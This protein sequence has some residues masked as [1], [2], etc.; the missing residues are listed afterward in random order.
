MRLSRVL[1]ALNGL[2]P[3]SHGQPFASLDAL[4]TSILDSI[5]SDMCPTTKRVLG[6]LL[7]AQG[8]GWRHT[9][10]KLGAISIVL[11]LDL[12]TIYASVNGCYSL[13]SMSDPEDA[14]WK[15]VTFYHASFGDYLLDLTQS[16]KFY[17]SIRD[18]EN[19]LLQSSFNI[20]QDFQTK[21]PSVPGKS[22]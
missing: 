4:Y 16:G 7:Y 9:L 14:G 1:S 13:L 10:R 12:S 6:A 15:P 22:K 2:T 17:I 18:A 11:G 8:A 21:C 19:D 3:T 20:W 5:P